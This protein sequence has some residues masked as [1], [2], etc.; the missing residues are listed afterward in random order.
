MIEQSLLKS[1]LYG[2]DI[3][4]VKHSRILL[5]LEVLLEFVDVIIRLAFLINGKLAI[6]KVVSLLFI[7]FEDFLL[8]FV[9]LV[10]KF[11]LILLVYLF[12]EDFS[13]ELSKGFCVSS[14]EGV[15]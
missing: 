9:D 1:L 10:L 14:V 4:V 5:V 6:V 3:I 12:V 11:A 2:L 13:V 8:Y 15:R 7:F